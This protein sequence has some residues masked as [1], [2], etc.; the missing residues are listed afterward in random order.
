M[1]WTSFLVKRSKDGA[2]L[3][4]MIIIVPKMSTQYTFNSGYDGSNYSLSYL[5]ELEDYPIEANLFCYD[6]DD[7]AFLKS[8]GFANAVG[9]KPYIGERWTLNNG[10][11]FEIITGAD[12]ILMYA[13]LSN[14]VK[15]Q[16]VRIV[17]KIWPHFIL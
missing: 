2:D 13:Y 11:Y 3:G 5:L 16:H 6:L 8:A 1:G 14:G 4:D 17:V 7:E 9:L 12:T 15:C 10:S